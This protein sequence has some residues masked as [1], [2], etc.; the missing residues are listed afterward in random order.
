MSLLN[1][2]GGVGQGV[3]QGVGFMQQ[4]KMQ[5][6]QLKL[7]QDRNTMLADQAKRAQAEFDQKQ[8]E[9][10]RVD[11]LS[12][13]RTSIYQNYP[14]A[15]PYQRERMFVD[16]AVKANKFRGDE[17]LT[18]HNNVQK[19][20][21]T[22]GGDAYRQMLTGN[23][24]PLQSLLGERGISVD[25]TPDGKN[26]Q[27]WQAGNARDAA[28]NLQPTVVPFDGILQMDGMSEAYRA[29]VEQRK[30]GMDALK[31]RAEIGKINAEARRADR[32]YQD[33]VI[34]NEDGSVTVVPGGGRRSSGA[35]K[36]GSKQDAA[37]LGTFERM[38]FKDQKGMLEY[39]MEGIGDD[40]LSF[41][42]ADGEQKVVPKVEA[43][44]A[45][46][47][48]LDLLVSAN[49]NLPPSM[50]RNMA[51]D[52]VIARQGGQ[53]AEGQYVPTPVLNKET[54]KWETAIRSKDKVVATVPA[55][56][57]EPTEQQRAEQESAWAREMVDSGM[58]TELTQ[59]LQKNP[60]YINKFVRA[61]NGDKQLAAQLEAGNPGILRKFETLYVQTGLGGLVVPDTRLIA[62]RNAFNSSKPG[63]RGEAAAR[64]AAQ[65]AG[66]DKPAFTAQE[67]ETARKAGVEAPQNVDVFGAAAELPARA[68]E[69]YQILA[70]RIGD[71]SF[72]NYAAQAKRTNFEDRGASLYLVNRI[73]ENPELARA[74]SDDELSILQV[75]AGKR[76]TAKGR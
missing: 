12:K 69:G 10:Q 50:L 53:L 7:A 73:N 52:M 22:V 19:L 6:E 62:R 24:K 56:V 58:A 26:L 44:T 70:D 66:A 42:G 11:E 9:Q 72:R 60:E 71:N 64:P 36:G 3:Q 31:T 28:G 14:D 18:A 33:E 13:M 67:L 49:T 55:A 75:S 23:I 35:G 27:L 47:Q 39:V 43:A 16:E 4:K 65:Q 61:L 2:L 37:P 68:A 21:A 74:F 48:E 76:I 30:A 32:Q 17:L 40:G 41:V 54:G 20:K 34:Q 25:F 5:D 51:R 8:A 59:T 46:E 29:A 1:I 38:G 45:I 57:V 15:N 63:L